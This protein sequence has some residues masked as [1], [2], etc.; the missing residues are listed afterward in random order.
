MAKLEGC[1]TCGNNTSENADRCPACGEPLESGWVDKI[2]RARKKSK[3]TKLL[4]WTVALVGLP[5]LAIGMA[6]EED[7]R[8]K[9]LK[10]TDPQ[11]YQKFID[12]LEAKV[13]K[14]PALEFNENLRLYRK[15]KNINPDNQRYVEKIKIYE[16]KMRAAKAAKAAGGEAGEKAAVADMRR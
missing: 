7:S 5:A 3:R 1:P 12:D 11:A 15:L 2:V 6:I 10:N 9:Y 8:I 13:A 16:Q 4:A 14:V